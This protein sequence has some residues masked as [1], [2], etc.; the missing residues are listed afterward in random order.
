MNLQ[1]AEQAIVNAIYAAMAWLIL[2]FGLLLQEHGKQILS[3]LVSRPE[4]AAGAIIAIACIAGL[5]YKSRLAAIVLFL[6]F[7]LPLVLR[8]AQGVFPS[9]VFLLFSLILLYFFLTGVLGTFR[10]HYL[11]TLDRDMNKP[12]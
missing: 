9:T 3:I 11:K 1:K 6:L 4:T 8:A 12:D 10:Y 7:L 5:F 2:D